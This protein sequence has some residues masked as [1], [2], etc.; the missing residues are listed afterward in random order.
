MIKRDSKQ[1]FENTLCNLEVFTVIYVSIRC[2]LNKTE[3][4]TNNWDQRRTRILEY[5]KI[6]NIQ[7]LGEYFAGLNFRKF[8]K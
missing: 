1:W 4:L 8:L 7:Q 6:R 2:F 5:S 3:Y